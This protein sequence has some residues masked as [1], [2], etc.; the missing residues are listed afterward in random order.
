MFFAGFTKVVRLLYAVVLTWVVMQDVSAP[1]RSVR[2]LMC[3]MKRL[4]MVGMQ[5]RWRSITMERRRNLRKMI[6]LVAVHPMR[7]R[8]C[9]IRDVG[10]IGHYPPFIT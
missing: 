6:A 5:G 10:A 7:K 8:L 4:T 3:M 2:M 1:D 9:T